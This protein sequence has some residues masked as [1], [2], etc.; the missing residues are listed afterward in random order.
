[1]AAFSRI[2]IYAC[3]QHLVRLE[4]SNCTLK[5]LYPQVE[6]KVKCRIKNILKNS[7]N[8]KTS[9]T[10]K[11]F[12]FVS[13]C[14]RHSRQSMPQPPL[15]PAK[16]PHRPT[17]PP[18]RTPERKDKRENEN[19]DSTWYGIYSNQSNTNQMI[20]TCLDTKLIGRP[21]DSHWIDTITKRLLAATREKKLS[22]ESTKNP[23]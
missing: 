5:Y 16:P 9:E 14:H 21:S 19:V 6:S 20:G 3:T 8:P 4:H 12:Q 17:K 7:Q 22:K 18:P 15:P 1:M 2:G 10:L 13:R 11:V 23:Y